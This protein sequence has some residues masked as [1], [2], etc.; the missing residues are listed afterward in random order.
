MIKI[1]KRLSIF[2]AI[3]FVV[4]GGFGNFRAK[5]AIPTTPTITYVGVSHSPLVVGD[6]EK[7]TVNSD[8][9]GNVQ[10]KAFLYSA[11]TNKWTALTTDYSVAVDAKTPYVL[12]ETSAFELGKYKLSVWV[13]KAGTTGS[14]TTAL[15]SYDSYYIANVNCVTK[16]PTNRV[17]ANGEAKFDVTGLKFTFNTIQGIGGITG[18]YCYRLHIYNPTTN[19]WIKRVTEYKQSPS[20]T[21]E[22]AGTYM[23]VVHANTAKSTT[24]PSYIKEVKTLANQASTYGTYEAWKTIM[25]TVKDEEIVKIVDST[26]KDAIFGSLVN[27]TMTAEGIKKYATVTN[28]QLFNGTSAISASTMLGTATTV[29]PRK[30]AGDKVTVKLID[31]TGTL[32]STIE[33][34]LTVFK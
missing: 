30:V 9:T 19:T 12:P 16:D 33:V 23:V 3:L 1:K 4:A 14:I 28:Y 7:F 8:Y 11:K 29:F 27:V 6:T 15:G 25:V 34:V 22:K 21:F 2:M 18:P 5:A 32:I 13:K 17:Y 26:V 31:A 10:Y 20:Y 24:W